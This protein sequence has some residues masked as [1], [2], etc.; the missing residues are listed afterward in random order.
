MSVS[1][2]ECGCEGVQAAFSRVLWI[3]MVYDGEAFLLI[4][5]HCPVCD[6]AESCQGLCR[7]E[8]DLFR[9]AL[10]PAAEVECT[11]HLPSRD[12]RCVYRVRT[13]S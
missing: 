12:D 8:L 10:G 7:N 5:H 9:D 4:E 3:R 11:Q 1:S 6:A 13:R 2:I